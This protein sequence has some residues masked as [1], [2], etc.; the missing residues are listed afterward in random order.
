MGAARS[1][2]LQH[3]LQADTPMPGGG[4]G[5]R[6]AGA[7]IICHWPPAQI[8]TPMPVMPACRATGAAGSA[9]L[10]AAFHITSSSV[11][12]RVTA[13]SRRSST[14]SRKR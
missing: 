6:P 7:W 14:P 9:S 13:D 8:C 1:L 4:G 12:L 11:M 3:H 2:R 5:R 10:V